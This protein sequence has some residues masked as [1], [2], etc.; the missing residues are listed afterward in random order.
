MDYVGCLLKEYE[1]LLDMG[2]YLEVGVVYLF[3]VVLYLFVVV[4]YL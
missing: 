4:L 2:R 1:Y 3:V